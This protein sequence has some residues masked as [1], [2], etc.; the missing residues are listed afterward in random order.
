[1]IL[2]AHVENIQDITFIPVEAYNQN[3][4]LFLQFWDHNAT[5]V[6]FWSIICLFLTLGFFL[7]RRSLKNDALDIAKKHEPIDEVEHLFVVRRGA[8]VVFSHRAY[9]VNPDGLTDG[10]PFVFNFLGPMIDGDHDNRV[11]VA[12]YPYASDLTVSSNPT[13]E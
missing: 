9:D 13:E 3:W 4:A 12:I 2:Q 11:T 10:V 6:A 1:M 5:G 8:E 7:W